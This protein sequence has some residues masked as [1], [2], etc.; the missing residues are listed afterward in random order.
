MLND[1]D[2]DTKV[3]SWIDTE[4]LKIV[5]IGLIK[6]LA[7][8]GQFLVRLCKIVFFCFHAMDLQHK[9]ALNAHICVPKMKNV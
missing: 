6:H 5:E 3:C 7:F 4:I 8:I 9:R 1:T 2:T